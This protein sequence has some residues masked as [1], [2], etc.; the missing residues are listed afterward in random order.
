MWRP[1]IPQRVAEGTCVLDGPKFTRKICRR[2]GYRRNAA[3]VMP[4]YAM[5]DE[6]SAEAE[7]ERK[8]ITTGTKRVINMANTEGTG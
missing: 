7:G 4:R 3:K 6:D 1:Y 2:C 8:A 5:C